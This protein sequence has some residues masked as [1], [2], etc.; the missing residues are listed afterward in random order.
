ME[1]K[2]KERYTNIRE[3][4]R[5]IKEL[6]G[7]FNNESMNNIDGKRYKKSQIDKNR[8]VFIVEFENCEQISISLDPDATIK[9]VG[10]KVRKIHDMDTWSKQEALSK[11]E[12]MNTT[13]TLHED[14]SFEIQKPVISFKK[15]DLNE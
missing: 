14:G 3:G 1:D 6:D 4:L 15:N 7:H 5:L 8:K 2:R 9:R 11:W 10:K 13:L 12:S